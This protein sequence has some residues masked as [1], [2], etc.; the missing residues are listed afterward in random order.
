MFTIKINLHDATIACL[1]REV[2]AA[3]PTAEVAFGYADGAQDEIFAAISHDPDD[4]RAANET[5]AREMEIEDHIA[6]ILAGIRGS[7]KK[8][9]GLP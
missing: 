3:Y 7:E 5:L 2:R 9:A 6:G 8:V 1:V 4:E